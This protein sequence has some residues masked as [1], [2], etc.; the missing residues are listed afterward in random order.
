M[1]PFTLPHVTRRVIPAAPRVG[2]FWSSI[3]A[4][5]DFYQCGARLHLLARHCV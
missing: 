1:A 2:P 5:R 4:V 3:A